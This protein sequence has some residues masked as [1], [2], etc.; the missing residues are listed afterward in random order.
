MCAIESSVQWLLLLIHMC[1]VLF[2]QE[3]VI[4]PVPIYKVKKTQKFNADSV[5]PT[6]TRKDRYRNRLPSAPATMP[7]QMYQRSL[8]ALEKKESSGIALDEEGEKPPVS[9]GNNDDVA[10]FNMET[11]YPFM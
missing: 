7:I 4:P 10:W 9:A 1:F 11:K 3:D 8:P 6:P 5:K 2:F